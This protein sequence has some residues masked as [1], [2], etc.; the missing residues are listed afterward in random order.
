[1][2]RPILLYTERPVLL[3]RELPTHEWMFTEKPWERFDLELVY[4]NAP[5]GWIHYFE[6]FQRE[7]TRAGRECRPLIVVESDVV[8]RLECFP[9]VLRCP[10]RACI[11]PY[12][13]LM[14]DERGNR[15]GA[16]IEQ[17]VRG[18]WDSRF[19][20]EGDQWAVD[21]DLGFAAF[22]PPSCTIALPSDIGTDRPDLLINEA[23]FRVLRKKDPRNPG[24][25]H[26]HYPCLVN[27]HVVWDRGDDAHHP[28]ERWAELHRV[29][30]AHLDPGLRS[31]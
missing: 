4:D 16:V 28:P 26:L 14:L 15:T 5:G 6:V 23:V 1:M 22:K 20:V 17:K 18:G 9:D 24:G 31:P 27:S 7:W 30:A 13:N 12:V 25:I 11:Y 29:H 2:A 19:A 10:E 8:P 3:P 21:G